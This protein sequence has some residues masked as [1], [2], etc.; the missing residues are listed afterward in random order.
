[1]ACELHTAAPGVALQLG[2]FGEE[3][4]LK[5]CHILVQNFCKPKTCWGKY[6]LK[7]QETAEALL[8]RFDWLKTAY[9][10]ERHWVA[11]LDFLKFALIYKHGGEQA[12]PGVAG[13]KQFVFCPRGLRFQ[14]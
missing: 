13:D 11:R 5:P 4:T 1:M 10:A 6:K 8:E 9:L 3:Q 12:D 14:P 7:P 2:D